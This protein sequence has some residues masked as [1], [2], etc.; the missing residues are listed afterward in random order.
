MVSK[1]AIEVVRA[2]ARQVEHYKLLQ[3]LDCAIIVQ[4]NVSGYLSFVFF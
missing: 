4:S 2:D 3:L 1:R